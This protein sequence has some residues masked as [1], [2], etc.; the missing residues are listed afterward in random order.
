MRTTRHPGQAAKGVHQ[1]FTPYLP[2]PSSPWPRPSAAREAVS[3][4]LATRPE[5]RPGRTRTY[6]PRLTGGKRNF[7]ALC[8]ALLALPDRASVPRTSSDSPASLHAALCRPVPAFVASKGQEKGDTLPEQIRSEGPSTAV[9]LAFGSGAH[10]SLRYGL[11]H[12]DRGKPGR[13]GGKPRGQGHAHQRR[14]SYK[15]RPS[16]VEQMLRIARF[17][18]RARWI[19]ERGGFMLALGQATA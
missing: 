16:D 6:N 3:V 10:R 5:S 13:A 19:D 1:G 11:A 9:R 17:E 8:R 4:Y 7:T 2:L 15:Y 14:G 12:E 18:P